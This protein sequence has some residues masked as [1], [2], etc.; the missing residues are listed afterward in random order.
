ML[1]E[2]TLGCEA[3]PA[4]RIAEV[5]H[6]F[7][8]A[9][10]RQRRRAT[11]NR[12]ILAHVSVDFRHQVVFGEAVRV[13]TWVERVGTGHHWMGDCGKLQI[14]PTPNELSLESIPVPY[15]RSIVQKIVARAQAES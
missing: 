6:E 4:G 5:P 7:R 9:G 2:Q 8:G 3:P 10:G 11:L 13:E 15:L 1:D 14:A 12:T